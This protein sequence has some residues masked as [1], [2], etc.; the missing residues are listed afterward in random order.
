M[1]EIRTRFLFRPSFEV[2]P[3]HVVG[4]TSFGSRRVAPN[5]GG[6]FEGPDVSGTVQPGARTGFLSGTPDECRVRC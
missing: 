5:S 2:G 4:A 1:R 3:H 6:T